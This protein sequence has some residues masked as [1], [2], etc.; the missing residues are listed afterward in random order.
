MARVFAVM[1]AA[2]VTGSL[3]FNFTTN[4]NAQLLAERFRGIVED[5]AL[6]GALLAAVYAVASL[7]QVVV[8]RLIDRVPLKPL[9]LGIVAAAD[10]A[11]GAGRAWR[12]AGGC[13]RAAGGD[14]V[15][16]SAPSRS[17]TR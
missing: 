11:A 9:Y 17:P 12:R 16:S 7:A 5:P 6:L 10:S 13:C 4:G 15:R 1:T 14:G 3:L 8:G 2:A